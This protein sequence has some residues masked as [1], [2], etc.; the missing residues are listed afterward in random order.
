[1]ILQCG[2]RFHAICGGMWCAKCA[3]K[4]WGVTCPKCRA[5]YVVA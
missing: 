2:H 1:V 4:G 5:A 3:A